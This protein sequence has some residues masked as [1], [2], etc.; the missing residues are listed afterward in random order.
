MTLA[1]ASN[2]AYAQKWLSMYSKEVSRF[3]ELSVQE[4]AV[5]YRGLCRA[6][7]GLLSVTH[8]TGT[9]EQAVDFIADQAEDLG[10]LRQALV[11]HVET[12]AP[13]GADELRAYGDILMHYVLECGA[14]PQEVMATAGEISA[15]FND[16]ASVVHR[17]R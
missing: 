2:D 15:R 8:W 1:T 13:E 14:S 16:D 7:D 3:S 10:N 17:L 5:I 6:I 11:C 4:L 12:R 9:S